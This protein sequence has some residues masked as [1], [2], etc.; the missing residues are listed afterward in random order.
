ME[1]SR[2]NSKSNM[3]NIE[4]RQIVLLSF[5]ILPKWEEVLYTKVNYS[6]L[7]S[8]ISNKNVTI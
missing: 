6:V 5:N 3:K 1:R 7:A 2:S 4:R 8:I